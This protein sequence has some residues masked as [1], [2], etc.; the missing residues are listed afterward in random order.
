MNPTLF[1]LGAGASVPQGYPTGPGLR[2]SLLE[3]LALHGS[4]LCKVLYTKYHEKE[5]VAFRERLRES[6]FKT[7]DQFLQHNPK[8]FEI[9]RLAIAAA[10][11]LRENSNMLAQQN[12][13]NWYPLLADQVFDNPMSPNTNEFAFVTFNYDRSLEAFLFRCLLNRFDLSETEAASIVN[14]FQIFHMYGKVGRLP[15]EEV[16]GREPQSNHLRSYGE[17]TTFEEIARSAACIRIPHDPELAK[18]QH[19]YLNQVLREYR[20]IHFIGFGYDELNLLRVLGRQHAYLPDMNG[21][22]YGLSEKAIRR[23][24]TNYPI[25]LD[26]KNRPAREYF[27]EVVGWE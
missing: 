6:A 22:S 4:P 18:G 15:W 11:I 2:Q 23:I 12:S 10:I 1:V 24:E 20:Q 3:E 25:K 21:T 13:Q 8:H 17:G 7:I 19:A 9:G 27:S 5:I 26:R 14:R 16:N